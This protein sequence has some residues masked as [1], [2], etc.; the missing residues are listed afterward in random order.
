M[1]VSLVEVVAGTEEGLTFPALIMRSMLPL[2]KLDRTFL[3]T[4]AV[5]AG[6]LAVV[7]VPQ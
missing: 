1:T 7:P 4:V 2:I 6:A 3:E 5:D